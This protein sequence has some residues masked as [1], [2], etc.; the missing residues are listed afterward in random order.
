MEW[1]ETK[2]HV[3]KLRGGILN[4]L[5]YNDNNEVGMTDEQIQGYFGKYLLFAITLAFGG[6][7]GLE[8]RSQFGNELC[9]ISGVMDVGIDTPDTSNLS[10]LDYEVQIET[11]QCSP[12]KDKISNPNWNH[13]KYVIQQLL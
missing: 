12:W 6:A 7:M 10:S 9:D 11:Q 13:I 4:I 3:M 2:K 5:K 8:L 1:A